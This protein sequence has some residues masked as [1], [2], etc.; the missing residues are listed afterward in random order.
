M[1]PQLQTYR[2]ILEGSQITWLDTP[3]NLPMK[4][5]VQVTFMQS[6]SDRVTRGQAMSIALE[7]LAQLNSDETID[8]LAWQRE[9]R[10]DRD[11]PG[12][13]SLTPLE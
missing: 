5:E 3:P 1:N 4:A 8:P 12:R 9:V 2:A 13:G 7:K 6:T 11:L 10:Q